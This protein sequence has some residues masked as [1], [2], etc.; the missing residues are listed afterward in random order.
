MINNLN[1]VCELMEFNP[2]KSYYKI[3]CSEDCKQTAIGQF[4]HWENTP[5]HNWERK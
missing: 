5:S 3:V 2:E 4:R 1:P